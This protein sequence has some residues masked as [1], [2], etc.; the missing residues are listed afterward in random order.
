VGVL[1]AALPTEEEGNEE[2]IDRTVEEAKGILDA[3]LSFANPGED[4]SLQEAL[5]QMAMFFKQF[6][7]PEEFMAALG[8]KA[9][10]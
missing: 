4:P 9:S 2:S 10:D 7:S 1:R 3:F 6:N 5:N 8:L